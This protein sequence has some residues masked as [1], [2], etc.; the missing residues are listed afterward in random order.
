LRLRF[1]QRFYSDIN[2]H[3]GGPSAPPWRAN[4]PV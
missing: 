4:L 3:R 2:G 1:S